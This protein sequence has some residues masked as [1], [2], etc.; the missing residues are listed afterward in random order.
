MRGWVEEGRQK[1]L[2][3][4]FVELRDVDLFLVMRQC[5]MNTKFNLCSPFLSFDMLKFKFQ[6]NLNFWFLIVEWF[7]SNFKFNLKF[8][9]LNRVMSKLESKFNLDF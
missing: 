6:S 5:G 8:G 9:S 2:P 4:L 7:K 3:C 1:L